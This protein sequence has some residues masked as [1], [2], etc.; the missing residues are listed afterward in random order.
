MTSKTQIKLERIKQKKMT[1]GPLQNHFRP[2]NTAYKTQGLSEN[3]ELNCSVWEHKIHSMFPTGLDHLIQTYYFSIQAI[4]PILVKLSY[5]SCPCSFKKGD[6]TC[7]SYSNKV[8]TGASLRCTNTHKYV[9]WVHV[10]AVR[11][12][13]KV[14]FVERLGC[15]ADDGAV[16]VP[17]ITIATNHLLAQS[18]T[19]GPFWCFFRLEGETPG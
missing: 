14:D 2:K 17:A 1:Q 11:A 9:F 16:V 10:V 7:Y 13:V 8:Y 12:V 19:L 6:S 15:Q 3:L 4:T 5:A 18:N